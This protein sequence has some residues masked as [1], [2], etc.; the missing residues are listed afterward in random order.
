MINWFWKKKEPEAA[1]PTNKKEDRLY[2][3]IQKVVFISNA[4]GSQYTVESNNKHG[5][6]IINDE[7]LRT[8]N[9]HQLYDLFETK[10]QSIAQL[11]DCSIIEIQR[12][13]VIL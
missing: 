9:I 12:Q 11:S 2:S 1:Q 3:T 13:N 6:R 10:Y 7:T 5:L 8:I 4:T